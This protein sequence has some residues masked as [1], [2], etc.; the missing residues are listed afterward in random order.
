MTTE[1]LVRL[2][3]ERVDVSAEESGEMPYY[4]FE[5]PFT[6]GLDLLSITDDERIA[7][8]W[9]INV[10]GAHKV[11]VDNVNDLSDLIKILKKTCP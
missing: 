11:W 8:H 4:Y 10:L 7:E 3:F 1:D 5:K 6:D 2:G 9:V